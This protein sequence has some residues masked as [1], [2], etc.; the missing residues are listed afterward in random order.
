MSFPGTDGIHAEFRCLLERISILCQHKGN[1][2][3]GAW[4]SSSKVQRNRRRIAQLK[5]R[6]LE[7]IQPTSD[8]AKCF[9]L[10]MR[11]RVM[12]SSNTAL[13]ILALVCPMTTE[14]QQSER[15]D[16]LLLNRETIER[17]QQSF[18]SNRAQI[19][20]AVNALI[21]EAD[22]ALQAAF[23]SVV[24]KIQTPPSGDKHDYMSLGPYWWPDT[25]K[26]DGL[27]YI[28]RDGEVNPEYRLVGDNERIDHMVNNV[29]TLALA[30]S[31]SQDERFASRAVRR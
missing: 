2:F 31:V 5:S 23:V 10:L 22:I 14:A 17:A 8:A 3:R 20:P 6:T 26:P 30:Y 24:Q 12:I 11:T 19:S 28:R 15:S 4:F 25:T 18:R 1:S 27:P 9:I 7:Y 21:K 13:V 29:S 16:L